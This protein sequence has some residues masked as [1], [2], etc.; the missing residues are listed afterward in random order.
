[1]HSNARA[2]VECSAVYT[3][4]VSTGP[5]SPQFVTPMSRHLP[6]SPSSPLLFLIF[7]FL[8][9]LSGLLSNNG[10]LGVYLRQ[11]PISAQTLGISRTNS[12]ALFRCS[13]E[14]PDCMCTSEECYGGN[15][16]LKNYIQWR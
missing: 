14:Q 9:F 1:M 6:A 13:L 16:V 15:G 7:F 8:L 12:N 4:L 5:R 2:R 3:S 11:I 10:K